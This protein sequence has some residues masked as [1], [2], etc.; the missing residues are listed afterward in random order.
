MSENFE[1]VSSNE[2]RVIKLLGNLINKT[3]MDQLLDETDAC[4]E[5]G[6]ANFVV[7]LTAVELINSSGIS[8]L[9]NI[10]TKARRSGGDVILCHI[11]EKVERLMLI[12][13]LNSIF[14]IA[15][16]VQQAKNRFE[17]N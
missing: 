7:D 15:D 4:I 10:L 12:T 13:K 8:M 9:V 5:N 6:T 2:I 1:I 16:D 11:S 14:Q 3:W 17:A